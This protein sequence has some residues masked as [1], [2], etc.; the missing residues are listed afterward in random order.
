VSLDGSR[1]GNDQDRIRELGEALFV[2]AGRGCLA[3]VPATAP[4]EVVIENSP[5]NLGHQWLRLAKIPGLAVSRRLRSA[6]SL[7]SPP[8]RLELTR[9]VAKQVGLLNVVPTQSCNAWLPH[10]CKRGYVRRWRTGI[11][12]L[13]RT[14]DPSA[15]LARLVP[16]FPPCSNRH[17]LAD[18]GL[19]LEMLV[20]QG[21]VGESGERV[22]D[23]AVGRALAVKFCRDPASQDAA[24]SGM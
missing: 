13:T 7:T 4:R 6:N 12:V 16:A 23:H 1:D 2:A 17:E 11:S 8:A 19:T 10:L 9:S 24:R 14:P 3:L 5:P 15:A 21:A 22:Y 18:V 20:G